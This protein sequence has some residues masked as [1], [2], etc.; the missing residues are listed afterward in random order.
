[1]LLNCYEWADSLIN[2]CPRYETG[3]TQLLAAKPYRVSPDVRGLYESRLLLIRSFQKT[4]VGLFRAALN[5]EMHPAVLHWLM[6]ETPDYLAKSYHRTLEGQFLRGSRG[7]PR[8]VTAVELLVLWVVACK[9]PATLQPPRVIS[10][11][12]RNFPTNEAASQ[13]PPE[14]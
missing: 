3:F 13:T 10:A 8:H 4:A 1:M 2:S 11:I 9:G 5:G 7:L 6:N 14:A 12:R